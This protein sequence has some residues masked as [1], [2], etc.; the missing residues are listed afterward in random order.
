MRL[1]RV[2]GRLQGDRSQALI[3]LHLVEV[4]LDVVVQNI[5]EDGG[6]VWERSFPQV[7]CPRQVE[8]TVAQGARLLVRKRDEFTPQRSDVDFGLVKW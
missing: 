1:L 8:L 5:R 2:A 4:P 6:F 7:S 3:Q